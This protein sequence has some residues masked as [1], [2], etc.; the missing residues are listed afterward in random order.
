ME[1]FSRWFTNAIAAKT[2]WRAILG[3]G[4]GIF[5]ELLLAFPVAANGGCAI[6][7][8]Q[9]GVFPRLAQA[10]RAARRC[11]ARCDDMAILAS[12]ASAQKIGTRGKQ[13]QVGA[14]GDINRKPLRCA[15]IHRNP[16][17][18]IA[19]LI[20]RIKIGDIQDVVAAS[21]RRRRSNL[22]FRDLVV[23]KLRT[24]I[25]SRDQ[26][27]HDKADPIMVPISV[28]MLSHVI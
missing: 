26:D 11:A 16:V 1:G 7:R 21:W 10:I 4:I 18:V 20:F 13:I 9:E 3:A 12:Q 25:D 17:Y 8:A 28:Q 19:E 22:R 24:K 27:S 23:V 15:G 6:L 2:D 5:A 14:L